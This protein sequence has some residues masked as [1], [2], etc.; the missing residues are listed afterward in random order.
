MDGT[1]MVPQRGQ[2]SPPS[3]R[4]EEAS[5]EGGCVLPVPGAWPSP[6]LPSSVKAHVWLLCPELAV[7]PREVYNPVNAHFSFSF[8]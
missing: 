4:P 3:S 8:F 2:R 6:P 7:F 5:G 1:I